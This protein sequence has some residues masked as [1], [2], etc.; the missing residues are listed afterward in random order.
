MSGPSSTYPSSAAIID[1]GTG[2]TISPAIG[3]NG[4][5]V[6]VQGTVLQQIEAIV[7]SDLSA[8]KKLI[9]VKIRLRADKQTLGGAIQS[10]ATLAKAASVDDPRTI[11]SALKELCKPDGLLVRGDLVGQAPRFAFRRDQLEAIVTAWV[12]S[13]RKADSDNRRPPSSGGGG[14]SDR[15]PSSGVGGDAAPP[16]PSVGGEMWQPPSSHAGGKPE[17]PSSSV[18]LSGRKKDSLLEDAKEAFRFYETTAAR[19]QPKQLPIP[20]DPKPW[21]ASIKARLKEHGL[22][23][24]RQVLAAVEHSEFHCG[25]GSNGWCADLDWLCKPKN[26]AKMLAAR[27]GLNGKVAAPL[28]GHDRERAAIELAD[29]FRRADEEDA[30]CAR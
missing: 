11:K 23:G 19:C 16:S 28:N 18:P 8:T 2:R 1:M 26:F 7:D 14:P 6:T 30:K 4:P 10:H 5:P 27:P 22:D 24:W 29:A 9:L 17:P 12:K 13:K 25:G 21:A 15:P 20:S 3:H